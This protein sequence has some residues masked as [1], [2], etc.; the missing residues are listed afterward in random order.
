V[1]DHF[2]GLE[3][4]INRDANPQQI[5]LTNY[6]PTLPKLIDKYPSELVELVCR[7]R[8]LRFNSDFCLLKNDCILSKKSSE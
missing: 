8:A 5:K 3:I 6:H 2:I 1:L 7:A 4:K